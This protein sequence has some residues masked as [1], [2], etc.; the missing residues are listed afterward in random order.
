MF[1]FEPVR[2]ILVDSLV[3]DI[4]KADD[5][6]VC[7]SNGDMRMYHNCAK[8]VLEFIANPSKYQVSKARLALFQEF[9]AQRKAEAALA[10]VPIPFPWG[11]LKTPLYRPIMIRLRTGP[12][13]GAD[14]LKAMGIGTD[15]CKIS[16]LV[17]KL[18][19]FAYVATDYGHP[20]VFSL[21]AKGRRVVLGDGPAKLIKKSARSQQLPVGEIIVRVT[22]C[23]LH[24]NVST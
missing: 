21:T 20:Q 19:K 7:V 8:E 14:L 9:L 3:F 18:I 15:C 10:D 11:V 6:S 16:Q 5:N 17:D 12:A 1:E 2:H 24:A 4:R 22:G 13:T 23:G